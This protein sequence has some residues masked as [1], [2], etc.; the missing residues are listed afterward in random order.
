M[1]RKETFQT[2][3]FASLNILSCKTQGRKLPS[4]R[5]KHF[6]FESAYIRNSKSILPYFLV[7]RSNISPQLGW[8]LHRFI[9]LAGARPENAAVF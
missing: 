2:N 9:D 7:I 8:E 4:N 1:K 5:V 6:T 3:T